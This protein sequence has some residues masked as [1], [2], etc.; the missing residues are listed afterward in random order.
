M[1]SIANEVTIGSM[2]GAVLAISGKQFL[3]EMYHQAFERVG[4]VDA[5]VDWVNPEVEVYS[6]DENGKY[7]LDENG[8][9]VVLRTERKRN[10]DNFATL[11]SLMTRLEPKEVSITDNRSIESAVDA[12]DAEFQVVS[13]DD[14]SS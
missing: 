1:T 8:E 10:G 6:K 4:G 11:L 2:P 13:E 12:I 9:R 5:V 7:V 3:R 14:G